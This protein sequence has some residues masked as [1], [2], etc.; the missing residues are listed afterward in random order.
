MEEVKGASLTKKH[1][2]SLC[3]ESSIMSEAGSLLPRE[4]RKYNCQFIMGS[5]T[6]V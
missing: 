1:T 5:M 3:P 2:L 4:F 6:N